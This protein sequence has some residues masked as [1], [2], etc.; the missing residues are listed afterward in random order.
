MPANFIGSPVSVTGTFALAAG[1]NAY[2][3]VGSNG[4]FE[5]DSTGLGLIVRSDA[6]G[7]TN[8]NVPE[9]STFLLTGCGAALA[10]LL[11]RHRA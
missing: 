1:A 2:F 7:Q 4:S 8:G 11:R 3:A 6:P 10:F 5:Y 9:P